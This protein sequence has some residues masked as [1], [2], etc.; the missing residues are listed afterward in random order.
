MSNDVEERPKARRGFAVMDRERV[1]EIGA[2]GGRANQRA[3]TAHRYT[4]EEAR[5][6]GRKSGAARRA[7]AAAAAGEAST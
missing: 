1:R 5:A 4:S 7:K 2:R 6:A 3:G